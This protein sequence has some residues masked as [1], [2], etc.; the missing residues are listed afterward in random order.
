MGDKTRA[1]ELLEEL[2][3]Y[4]AE[5]MDTCHVVFF[6]LHERDYGELAKILAALKE[7]SA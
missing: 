7:P 3:A 6:R 4:K 5:Q 2:L 1:I